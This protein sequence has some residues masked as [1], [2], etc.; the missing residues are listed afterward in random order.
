MLT[1]ELNSSLVIFFFLGSDER[2]GKGPFGKSTNILL[3]EEWFF[4]ATV[5]N[6]VFLLMVLPGGFVV[7]NYFVNT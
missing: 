4:V 6:N 1:K 7:K 2:K 5:T 3:K